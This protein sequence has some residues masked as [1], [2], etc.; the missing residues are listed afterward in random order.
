MKRQEAYKQVLEDLMKIQMFTG[1]YDAVHGTKDFMYGILTV[2]KVI[3]DRAGNDTL[4]NEFIYN[5]EMNKKE[6]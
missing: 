3:A 4:L 5:M 1:T 6:D 2:M